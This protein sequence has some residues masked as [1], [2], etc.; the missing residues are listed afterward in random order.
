MTYKWYLI[1]SI[2]A[3]FLCAPVQAN[4]VAGL[5]CVESGT[6]GEAVVEMPFIPFGDGTIPTFLS[7][8]FFGDGGD[9]SDRLYRIRGDD[10]GFT[11]AVFAAGE[12]V[13]PIDGSVFAYAYDDI[14]NRL[15]SH[16]FGTNTI[17][18]NYDGLICAGTSNCEKCCCESNPAKS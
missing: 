17:Y 1:I 3:C 13:D 8:L 10:G 11:N 9:D 12:W 4:D 5:K 15:W 2:A 16:E 6:N 14:G 7:G 18:S